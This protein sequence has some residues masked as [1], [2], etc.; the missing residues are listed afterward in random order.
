MKI[1]KPL[2]M[3]PHHEMILE[4]RF[5]QKIGFLDARFNENSETP[6]FQKT[7]FLDVMFSRNSMILEI[8]FFEK[9]GFLDARFNENSETPFFQKTGFLVL[10]RK[11][12]INHY[13]I[14]SLLSQY[15]SVHPKSCSSDSA[16]L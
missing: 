11:P 7:G 1:Q 3:A 12:H 8:R 15:L 10:I 5:F 2:D 9:I 14:R 16:L 4:I 13:L 6:F